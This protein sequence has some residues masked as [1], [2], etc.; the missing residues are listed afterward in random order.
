MRQDLTVRRAR[1]EPSLVPADYPF[2]H[3]IRV[4]FAETDTMGIVHHSRYFP[5]LEEARVAYLRHIDH[6]YSQW[7]AAGLNAAVLEAWLRYRQPLHFDDE[8]DVH[9][10]LAAAT[11]T[12]FEMTY[13]LTVDDRPAATGSTV[14]GMVTTEGRPTRLPAW[15]IEL[16][17]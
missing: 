4:R 14:H 3:R 12:T 1:V 6:P 17:R 5:Y 11:R 10:R 9:L 7:Q 8:V 16:S 13:L 15:L 2:R